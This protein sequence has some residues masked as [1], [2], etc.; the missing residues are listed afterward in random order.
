M[1]LH[2]GQ[3][4]ASTEA[5]LCLEMESETGLGKKGCGALCRAAELCKGKLRA[6]ARAGRGETERKWKE[7]AGGGER[8]EP[9]EE[10]GWGQVGRDRSREV[11]S[12]VKWNGI[13]R[14]K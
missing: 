2:Q 3:A 6:G 4:W 11:A 8:E 7:G 1:V 14:D 10:T 13:T 12:E 9:R 5:T